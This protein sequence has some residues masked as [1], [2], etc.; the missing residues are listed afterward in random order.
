MRSSP[1]SRVSSHPARALCVGLEGVAD[2]AWEPYTSIPENVERNGLDSCSQLRAA[3][4]DETP[5][6]PSIA[7]EVG[8]TIHS[9]CA[10]VFRRVVEVTPTEFR[11][12]L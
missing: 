3:D 1:Q 8:Y 11:A 7:L 9:H 4:F 12:A 10:R 2:I 6:T 5:R